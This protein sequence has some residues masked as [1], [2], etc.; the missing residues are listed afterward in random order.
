MKV[1]IAVDDSPCSQAALDAVADRSWPE[2]SEFR[3]L[4][5]ME[6]LSIQY[7]YAG[8]Y[9]MESVI[10]V[11][12]Q[13]QTMRQKYIDEKVAKLS[14]L[15][16]KGRVCGEVLEGYIAEVIITDAENWH[17][18]LIVVGSHGRKGMQRFFVGSVAERVVSHSPCSVEVVKSKVKKETT[19]TDNDHENQGK[20]LTETAKKG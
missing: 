4:S 12:R 8:A 5:V 10:E 15:F 13:L 14:L 20:V 16:G 6:P 7:G 2:G 1:L 19:G 9:G 11:E 17:A 18:D 3:V